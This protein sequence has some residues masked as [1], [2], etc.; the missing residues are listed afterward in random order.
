MYYF[1]STWTLKLLS[2]VR[3]HTEIQKL[4]KTSVFFFWHTMSKK[5]LKRMTSYNKWISVMLDQCSYITP[6]TVLKFE[7]PLV[8]SFIWFPTGTLFDLDVS[9]VLC[10]HTKL[11][12]F[13]SF[14]NRSIFTD[15][16]AYRIYNNLLKCWM[17]VCLLFFI[18]PF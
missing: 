1:V 4:V 12:K 2:L 17:S 7:E 14:L 15:A 18:V 16:I 13:Y 8:L 11:N 10:R 6:I 5:C 3:Y 9:L